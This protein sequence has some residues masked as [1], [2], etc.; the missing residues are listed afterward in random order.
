LRGLFEPAPCRFDADLHDEARGCHAGL[1]GEDAR[2]VA[3]THPNSLGHLLDGERF[4]QI[5]QHPNMQ[6]SYG[7]AVGSLQRE[8]GAELRLAARAA[9]KNNQGARDEQREFRPPV[10]LDHGERQIDACCHA[11]RGVDGAVAD[12]DRIGIELDC[13]KPFGHLLAKVPVRRRAPPVEQSGGGQRE[14]AVTD[15]PDPPR[16]LRC[17]PQPG[18]EARDLFDLRHTVTARDNQSVEFA[19]D[20]TKI[21]LRRN[22]HPTVAV[23]QSI[24][25]GRDQFYLI[26][27]L[28]RIEVSSTELICFSEDRQWPGNVENL[29]A[30]EGNDADPASG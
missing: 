8:R 5:I 22:I 30:W 13:G 14:C 28:L 20:T 16:C 4:A 19:F 17:L 15:R 2:E 9:Q 1:L 21:G 26:G 7:G 27:R 24:R 6:L 12:E 23:N 10:F 3:R 11:G 18:K 25:L 29:R